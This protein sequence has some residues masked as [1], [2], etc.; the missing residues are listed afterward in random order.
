MS[1]ASG[2][3]IVQDTRTGAS[4]AAVSDLERGGFEVVK[5][6]SGRELL[7]AAGRQRPDAVVVTG[8]IGVTTWRAW[9]ESPRLQSVP[10]VVV[11]PFKRQRLPPWPLGAFVRPEVYLAAADLVRGGM[12]ADTVRDVIARGGGRGRPSRREDLGERLLWRAGSVTWL[13]GFVVSVAGLVITVRVGGDG[14]LW[15]MAA[16]F[17]GS[18]LAELGQQLGLGQRVTLRWVPALVASFAAVVLLWRR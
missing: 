12:A 6:K 14:L 18:A 15:G 8:A 7:D 13:M 5:V 11:G 17:G 10:V 3:V 16:W 2:R 9:Q 1:A 4:S